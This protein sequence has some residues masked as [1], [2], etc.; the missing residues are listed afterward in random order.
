[1][2]N[3]FIDVLPPWVE[4]GLQPA[5]YDLESGTVLQQTA[6]MYAKVRDLNDAFNQFSED[7][8]NEVN[9]FEQDTNDEIERFEQATNDEIERFEGVIND[10]VEEYIEKFND[11][12]D[13][14]EDY[15]ENL[16][17]QEEINNKLDD[18]V[19]QGTLQ[20]IITTYIQSNV[21]WTFDDVAD[22]ASAT[23]LVNGSFARTLGYYSENDGGGALY[24][25]TDT[26]TADG[27]SVIA[28]S[29]NLYAHLVIENGEVNIL[30]FGAKGDGTTDN[31]TAFNNAIAYCK[32]IV[33]PEGNY[34]VNTTIT[35]TSDVY[36]YSKS[37]IK[38]WSGDSHQTILTSP[39]NDY[40]F[41]GT[42]GYSSQFE[43]LHFVGYGIH[44]PCGSFIKNCEFSGT[45]GIT[46][47]RA[48]TIT[49]CSFHNCTTAGIW[50]LTDTKVFGNFFYSNGTAI[51]ID[52]T[53]S[54]TIDNNKIEWNNLGI[55]IKTSSYNVITNN[56]FDRNTTYGLKSNDSS[57]ENSIT[58]NHFERNLENHL[59]G[60]FY[61][62]VI[63]NNIFLMK[64]ITDGDPQSDVKPTV[65]FEF[66]KL[67][68][69]TFTGNRVYAEE[70]THTNPTFNNQNTYIGNTFND[71]QIDTCVVNL[72]SVTVTPNGQNALNVLWSSIKSNI[73]NFTNGARFDL[74]RLK[75]TISGGN[76]RFYTGDDR[77]KQV[78][79]DPY[80][81]IQINLSNP[82]GSEVTYTVE[83]TF[84]NINPLY[85]GRSSS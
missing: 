17:V 49:E 2:Q 45:V 10:T 72:G 51:D 31:T 74:A 5:F 78:Y 54:N 44:T 22:M 32:T 61:Y 41:S 38:A 9:Q 4:T 25:I 70:W 73:L 62:C 23:N 37:N 46:I 57:R 60:D 43:N 64:N 67:G 26:G 6:R 16:D 36:I 15:F 24:K 33:V 40:F 13:Y 39:D 75:V 83:A 66:G 28:L 71:K 80:Y 7:V 47:A 19:E 12:H 14:V 76:T 35:L 8:S 11:L 55:D 1:M 77:I 69:N 52:G 48:C 63:N 58:N 68:T 84:D 81:N 65:A 82:T 20:E 34:K 21:A 56:T 53:Y 59:Y 29:G 3:I 30:Q 79:Y 85:L 42:F 18:M 50:K 27:G